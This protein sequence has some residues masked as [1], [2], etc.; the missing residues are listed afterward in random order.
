MMSMIAKKTQL[1]TIAAALLIQ[2]GVRANDIAPDI[3]YYPVYAVD[4]IVLDG[5]LSEWTDAYE[6]NSPIFRIPKGSGDGGT[7]VTFTEY[8][9]GT[10]SGPDDP[11]I[12][13][14]AGFDAE[15]VYVGVLVIDDFHEHGAAG[16]GGTWNGD[17]TQIHIANGD[18]DAQIALYN[19]ALLGVE[20]DPNF[21][22]I[23]GPDIEDH[24]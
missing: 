24:P 8:G 1:L 12:T 4:G 23:C 7:T 16:G 10:W 5:D 15:N 20:S 18:R 14:Q 17:A 19:F 11:G 9:G 6:L 2:I 3:E 13:F 22:P 21:F